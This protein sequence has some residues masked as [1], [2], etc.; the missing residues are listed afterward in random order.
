MRRESG[1]AASPIGEEEGVE[2]SAQWGRAR[3]AVLKDPVAGFQLHTN[4]RRESAHALYRKLQELHGRR[5]YTTGD[6]PAEDLLG[7]LRGR[8]ACRGGAGLLLCLFLH[9]E[10]RRLALEVAEEEEAAEKNQLSSNAPAPQISTMSDEALAEEL[11][12][13]A[14]AKQS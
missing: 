8:L 4:G 9:V 6:R 3:N 14:E 2:Q 5:R 1:V 7:R 10:A 12:R 11:R 13:R